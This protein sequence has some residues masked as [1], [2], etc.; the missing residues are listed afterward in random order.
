M[1]SMT[2]FGRNEISN[3]KIKAVVEIKAVNHRFCDIFIKGPRNLGFLDD[4]I[5]KII[6][7]HVSRGKIDVYYNYENK[8]ES[9]IEIKYN[10][11]LSDQYVKVLEDVRNKYGLQDSISL[12]DIVRF[13]DIIETETCIENEEELWGKLEPLFIDATEKLM[14]MRVFEG[15]KTKN[16]MREKLDAIEKYV[17]MLEERAPEVPKEFEA[18]LRKNV[19]KYLEDKPINDDRIAMEIAVFADKC[20][21]DE[22]ITR[23]KSHINM[24]RETIEQNKPIGRKLDFMMQEM[25]REINTVGSKANDLE[26]TK[27]V[28]EVKSELEKIREQVQNIE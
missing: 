17:Y 22:E 2:G 8:E 6:N 15:E 21:V 23:L 3:E 1:N 24:F 25:N 13:P 7:K 18:R 19:E 9:P 26:I 28:V 5:K 4:K 16:D 12:P 11:S 27:T 10:K 20:T 14:K